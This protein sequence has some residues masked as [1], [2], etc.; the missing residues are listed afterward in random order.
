LL[1]ALLSAVLVVEGGGD[2]GAEPV[3]GWVQVVT[4]V[5]GLRHRQGRQ[6]GGDLVAAGAGPVGDL[7]RVPGRDQ[8]GQL[9]AH[10]DVGGG[11]E[12]GH[13]RDDVAGE[14]AGREDV[15]ERPA[16]PA[17][18]GHGDVAGRGDAAE[19]DRASGQPV[20]GGGQADQVLGVERLGSHLGAEVRD[21]AEVDVHQPVPQRCEVFVS[22]GCEA[23]RD[24]GCGRLDPGDEADGEH[25]HDGIVRP[26]GEG[27]PQRGEVEVA[28]GVYEEVSLLDELVE[29][30]GDGERPRRRHESAPGPDQDGVAER[31]PDAAQGATRRGHGQVQ[32]LGRGGN[33]AL[34]QQ[35]VQR[36]EQ[37][38]VNVLR[39]TQ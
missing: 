14:A 23:E 8:P 13:D 11:G 38:P 26:D 6:G 1:F 20:A 30:A 5:P 10:D 7:P 3:V 12:G 33:A 39:H 37:V 34:G 29:P 31:P 15:V 36:G 17:T 4:H 27:P 9:R 28:S 18:P 25:A 21:H 2:L 16:G 32:P 35:H 19:G 22:L 24:P